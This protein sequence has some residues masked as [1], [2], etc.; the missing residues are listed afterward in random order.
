MNSSKE[1]FIQIGNAVKAARKDKNLT[2]QELSQEVGLSQSAISMIENGLRHPSIQTLKKFS[3][4]LGVDFTKIFLELTAIETT[5][6][7]PQT[8]Q[9]L[10]LATLDLKVDLAPLNFICEY[11]DPEIQSA[12]YNALTNYLREKLQDKNLHEEINT[13]MKQT[14]QETLSKKQSELQKL[15]N[16]IQN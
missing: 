10:H 2:M 4:A 11:S 3:K 15:Y 13:L 12:I 1:V 9:A 5:H 7:Y 6:S 16:R 8:A 14:I